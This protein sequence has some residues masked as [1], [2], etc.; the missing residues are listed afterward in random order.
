MPLNNPDVSDAAY[1]AGWDGDTTHAPSKNAVYDKIQTLGGGGTIATTIAPL[2]GDNAGNAAA[3][4]VPFTSLSAF[5]QSIMAETDFDLFFQNAT[6]TPVSMWNE[7]GSS[8]DTCFIGFLDTAGQGGTPI[9][10]QAYSDAGNVSVTGMNLDGMQIATDLVSGTGA[11]QL[12][13]INITGI[14]VEAGASAVTAIGLLVADV[15]AA[16]NN[17]AIKTGKGIVRF[18]GGGTVPSGASAT[19]DELLLP[20]S[21]VTVTGTTHITTAKGFNKVSFY[22]PTYTDSSAVTIDQGATVYIEDGPA[23]AGSVTLTA[24]Y[25]LWVD[26]GKVRIDGELDLGNTGGTNHVLKQSS[27]GGTV[28]SGLVDALVTTGVTTSPTATQTDTITH[29][30]GKTPTV[31]RLYGIGTFTSSS[32]ATPTTSC[33][34]VWSSSGNRCIYQ[35]YNTAAITTTQASAVSSTFSIRLDTGANSFITGIVQNV[36]ATTFQIAWTETGTTSAQNYM[37]EAS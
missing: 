15:S 23:A 6:A 24:P 19:L 37:W 32:S 31:I 7:N 29:G 27:A 2:V 18:G 26:N 33:I 3:A 14:A 9:N 36:G 30:L 13:G 20:A 22:K 11:T 35:G 5:A 28:T 21:T 8:I 25:A 16:T 17:Y 1:G 4:G 12:T 10:I 34:G